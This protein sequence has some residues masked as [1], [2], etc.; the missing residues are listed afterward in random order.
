MSNTFSVPRNHLILGVCLPLAMVMGYFLAE[1]LDSVSMGVVVLVLTV[2]SIPL[3]MRWH[4]PLLLL[5]WNACI[6]PYFFPGRPYMWMLMAIISCFFA[7][8]ARAAG[9]N[10][11]FLSAPCL[12]KSLLF[13]VAVVI[14]T[15]ALRG[16]V[17]LNSF[18]S[19][20]YGGKGYVMI[21]L[22]I[23][24]Y[25]AFTSQPVPSRLA[26]WYVG[27]FF[28]SGITSVISNLAYIAGPKFWF[29]YDL[30]PP[31]GAFSQLA[32]DYSP[33][34]EIVRISGA[35][36]AAQAIWC[37][38][39]AIY[40]LEGMFEI[41]KP[42]RMLVLAGAILA[43][44]YGGFR[45]ALAL[46]AMTFAILFCLEK[47]WRTRILLYVMAGLLAAGIGLAAFSEDLPLSMQR[48]VSFLPV[49][50]DPM[51]EHDAQGSTTWRI[52]MWER[53]LPE[54]PQY[55]LKGKGYSL[56]P[57][58]MYLMN[59]SVR[60]GFATTAD[61]AASV[62]D[63]HNGPLSII[64]PFGLWG[65]AAFGWF[66]IAGI[67]VMHRNYRHGPAELQRINTFLYAFFLAKVVF[68]VVVFGSIY[69]DMFQFAGLVGFSIALNGGIAG[70]GREADG[71]PE[72]A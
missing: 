61:F 60:R 51:A 39:L 50:V 45:S 63:Y 29:L 9:S 54:V 25:F 53:L 10:H 62:G 4:Y 22:A 57:Q 52:E 3:F 40:G 67:W 35:P 48:A 15:A 33:N 37:F 72:T 44:M 70:A 71:Q 28:L 69:S 42:W 11:R 7:L 1:P 12:T 5:S 34:D 2:L 49:K 21:L 17:G 19:T 13:V 38:L 18:G 47:L 27:F 36:V 59:E 64:I 20:S 46:F 56:D 41:R 8:L 65:T 31:E 66:L 23:V 32:A 26:V 6:N 24:G 68:F 43:G 14:A 55:L 30:F 16:G 58:D